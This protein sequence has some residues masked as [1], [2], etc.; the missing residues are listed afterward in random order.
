MTETDA[1]NGPGDV[2]ED[3][4]VLEP[5][6]TLQGQIGDDPLDDGIDA[7]DGWSAGEGYG[8]TSAEE[9]AGESLEQLLA[10]EEPDADRD[11]DPNQPD[12]DDGRWGDQPAD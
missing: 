4:G 9:R 11:D 3:D 7:G 2:G 12:D 1:D 6:D 10:Q 8:T 5:A